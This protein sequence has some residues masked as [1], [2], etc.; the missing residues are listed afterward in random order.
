MIGEV[1]LQAPPGQTSGG[2]TQ[3]MSGHFREAPTPQVTWYRRNP[4]DRRGLCLRVA[5]R[6]W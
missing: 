6:R 2:A 3:A 1:A 4:L 5:E